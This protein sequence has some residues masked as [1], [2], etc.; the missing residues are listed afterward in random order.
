MFSVWFLCVHSLFIDGDYYGVLPNSNIVYSRDWMNRVHGVA[1]TNS[2]FDF[3]DEFNELDCTK[4]EVQW[5][6]IACSSY[7]TLRTVTLNHQIQ[8]VRRELKNIHF[9]KLALFAEASVDRICC[10]CPF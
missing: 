10:F 3:A 6:T 1:Q 5:L 8:H 7:V 4:N 2:F 9:F